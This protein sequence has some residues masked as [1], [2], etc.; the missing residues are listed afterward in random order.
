M[1]LDIWAKR[2]GYLLLLL[3]CQQQQH[4]NHQI[5]QS[6]KNV[7]GDDRGDSVCGDAVDFGVDSGV[8]EED[9]S[10]DGV[11]IFA[12]DFGVYSG[13]VVVVARR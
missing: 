6:D 1:E 13:V 3:L 2:S 12:V 8:I 10:V 9:G 5:S 11:S 7:K 4:P